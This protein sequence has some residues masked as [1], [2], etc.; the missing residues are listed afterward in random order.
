MFFANG[1]I[2]RI[3]KMPAEMWK[4]YYERAWWIVNQNPKT[5]ED[6]KRLN[7]KSR[8]KIAEECFG[9]YYEG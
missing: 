2:Y 3:K 9:C 5:D 1:K 4:H 6:I 8:M 7:L